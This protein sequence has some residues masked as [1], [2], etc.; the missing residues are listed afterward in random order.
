MSPTQRIDNDVE[1]H[2]LGRCYAA[3]RKLFDTAAVLSR[4]LTNET[5]HGYTM[6]LGAG[7]MRIAAQAALAARDPQSM[8]RS[9]RECGL[10]ER[11]VRLA[12]YRALRSGAIDAKTYDF[13]FALAREASRHREHER[14]RLRRQLLSLALI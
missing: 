13:I 8:L 12:T 9:W 7:C 5:E 2:A 11:Q 1:Q 6:Y 4:E 14:Q 10:G 3:Q